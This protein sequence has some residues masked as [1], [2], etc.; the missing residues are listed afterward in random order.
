MVCSCG[1][2]QPNVMILR[3]AGEREGKSNLTV[4]H[5]CTL[6]PCVHSSRTHA[7]MKMK[8]RFSFLLCLLCSVITFIIPTHRDNSVNLFSI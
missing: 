2:T 6:I 1:R 8:T 4:H 5:D 3:P 7:R